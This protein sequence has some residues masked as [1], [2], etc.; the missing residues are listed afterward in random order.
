MPQEETNRLTEE[1]SRRD[2]L[3]GL[4]NRFGM[5]E[6]IEFERVRLRRKKVPFS[7]LL[8]NF[9]GFNSLNERFGFEEGDRVLRE[10]A[11]ALRENLREEDRVGRLEGNTFLAVLPKTAAE[12]ANEAGEKVR[13]HV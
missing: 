13:R 10:V 11:K 7:L 9:D 8:M 6:R 5:L 1:L 3:T 2:P 12:G 4:S